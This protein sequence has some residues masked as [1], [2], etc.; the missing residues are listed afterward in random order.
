MEQAGKGGFILVDPVMTG[1][2]NGSFTDGHAMLK[3]LWLKALA[4]LFFHLGKI[5]DWLAPYLN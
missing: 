3:A 4:K 1:K 2:R 5:H